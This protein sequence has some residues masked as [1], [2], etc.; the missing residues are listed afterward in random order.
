MMGR[1]GSDA[2]TGRC[3]DG[4]GCGGGGTGGGGSTG[5]GG[6]A[7]AEFYQRQALLSGLSPGSRT[8]S[9][10][11]QRTA[12]SARALSSQLSGALVE[13]Q[14][15]QPQQRVPQ[16]QQSPPTQPPGKRNHHQYERLPV[17]CSPPPSSAQQQQQQSSSPKRQQS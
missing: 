11:G 12:S 4:S 7:A 5:G 8:A 10:V 14:P 3:S 17:Q 16:L 13:M 15:Q 2:E 6:G 9:G 1:V